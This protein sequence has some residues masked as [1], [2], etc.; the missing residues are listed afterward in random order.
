MAVYNGTE[1]NDTLTGGF[2]HDLLRGRAGDDVLDG[3]SGDDTVMGGDGFD[4]AVFQFAFADYAISYR[5]GRFI[6]AGPFGTDEVSGVESFQFHDGLKTAFELL[7]SNVIGTEGDDHLSGGPG[8]DSLAG[9]G[10]ADH[11]DGW[12]ADDVL[13]GG[14]GGDTLDGGDGTDRA[15]FQ[16]DF[17]DY[18]VGVDADGLYVADT[19]ADRDGTDRIRGVE[20]FQFADG[21]KTLAELVASNLTG[22]EGADSLAGGSAANTIVGA[23]GEDTLHGG[24]GDDVLRGGAGRDVLAGGAGDDFVDG[25]DFIDYVSFSGWDWE[26]AITFD[27]VTQQFT[28]VDQFPGEH[29]DDGTDVVTNVEYFVFEGGGNP[30]DRVERPAVLLSPD[31]IAPGF[32]FTGT[33]GN[34]QLG[35]DAGPDTVY[36]LAGNDVL[37]ATLGDDQ[38]HGGEGNDTLVAWGSDV[39]DGGAGHDVAVIH[40]LQYAPG[41]TYDNATDTYT[42]PGEN[43]AVRMTGIEE[44][45]FVTGGSPQRVA[46]DELFP[47]IHANGN[48]GANLMNGGGARDSLSGA[49]GNDTLFGF[50]GRDTL[51]GGGGDD[52][53][54]GG[55]GSDVLEG[56]EGSDVAEFAGAFSSFVVSYD[57][58]TQKYI[59]AG[60]DGSDTV[61]GVEHFDFVSGGAVVRMSAADIA[62]GISLAGTAGDDTLSGSAGHDSLAAGGGNDLLTGAGGNDTLDGGEGWDDRAAYAGAA[63][64]S[65]TITY[66]SATRQYTLVDNVASRHGT[67]VVTGVETFL[68]SDG[69]KGAGELL[70]GPALVLTGT[71]AGELL[72][73]GRGD[74]TIAGAGGADELR[75]W[76][77]GDS[78]KGDA[79]ADTLKGGEGDD[80]LDGG[81]DQDIAFFTGDFADYYV[82]YDAATRWYHVH[83]GIGSDGFDRVRNVESF[84]FADGLRTWGDVTSGAG[85]DGVVVKGTAASELLEGGTGYDTVV[86][87][88]GA[89]DLRGHGGGD[90]LVGYG[91]ADSLAGGAGDDVLEGGAGE[92]TAVFDGNFADYTIGYDPV[93]RTY[94]LQDDVGSGGFDQVKDVEIFRFGDGDVS[95]ADVTQGAGGDGLALTGTVAG[96]TLVGG[97]GYD[98]LSGGDGADSLRGQEAPDRLHGNAGADTLEGG[99]GNDTLDGGA[100]QDVARF[101]GAF[102][103]YRIG[104]NAATRQY[105]V[106]DND[107]TD[108][109][110]GIDLVKNVEVFEFAGGVFVDWGAVTSGNGG[111]GNLVKGTA[112]DDVLSAGP[113][114][115]TVVGYDGAD[116]LS[117][118]DAGDFLR[119]DGGADTLRGGRGNDTLDGGV[120][121]DTARYTGAFADYTIEFEESTRQYS[122]IDNRVDPAL[123]EGSDLVS[124]VEWFE[125]SDGTLT[126]TQVDPGEGEGWSLTGTSG[127]DYL[128]GNSG[129][130]SLLGL[131]GDDLLVALTGNDSLSGGG[132]NDTLSGGDGDDVM[133]GG[134]GNDRLDAGPGV[135]TLRGGTGADTF[136]FDSPLDPADLIEDFNAAEDLLQFHTFNFAGLSAGPLAPEALQSGAGNIALTADVRMIFDTTTGGLY[137]DADGSGAAA[138]VQLA[139]L[140][141][142][143][144]SGTLTAGNFDIPL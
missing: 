57:G 97:T 62:P 123:N 72:H 20:V 60:L 4:R 100:D 11:L 39:L 34:D 132:G 42:L 139:T 68:F 76:S 54:V 115:D 82:F 44:V 86:G 103:G 53:L 131:G 142:A 50:A 10:G 117:G 29:G 51:V 27:S 74:D 126:W 77:G 1:G 23:G 96:D 38:L 65:F 40:G 8:A 24:A 130:D 9:G 45:D 67:D 69:A 125:F 116:S 12:D 13:E 33:S 99:L 127:N 95:W 88:E 28:V 84:Q 5:A 75:G 21:V 81:A 98:T 129:F 41:P 110:D 22:T 91:G 17:A 73:G 118:N 36:G 111:D 79:G 83:D 3:S 55:S 141:L 43:G 134:G 85:G 19:I 143:G 37:L 107:S 52:K 137:Y 18:E 133:I 14:S 2:E 46:A 92:D 25:G 59:L 64:A 108:G 61:S 136:R 144:M 104:Y 7:P 89:D 70:A 80:T 113:G 138:A 109:V 94:S 16:G 58:A 120:G 87:Y 102:A 78:L 63:F 66:N 90:R 128:M 101:S 112:A 71:A 124:N 140:S 26:Y 56:G 35:G 48:G 119:G 135:D 105:T 32:V 122:V 93:S 49:G 47:G 106:E 31:Y 114:Y 6:L 15:I 30:W 121:M